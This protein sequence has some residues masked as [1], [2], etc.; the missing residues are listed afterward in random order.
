[1]AEAAAAIGLAASI[2]SLINFGSKLVSR[3]KEI[4][5]NT[6]EVPV[7]FRDVSVQLPLLLNLVENLQAWTMN[8]ASLGPDVEVA[9]P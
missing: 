6:E 4:Q 2:I 9:S 5:E 8:N 7:V 1:M 3:I